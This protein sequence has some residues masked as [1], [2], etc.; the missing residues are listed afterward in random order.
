MSSSIRGLYGCQKRALSDGDPAKRA[1]ESA[2]DA[3]LRLI[4]V[5]GASPP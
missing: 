3:A 5:H 4:K 2:D 1:R